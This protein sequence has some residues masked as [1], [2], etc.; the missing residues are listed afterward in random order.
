M[1]QESERENQNSLPVEHRCSATFAD[2]NLIQVAWMKAI[3]PTSM[4]LGLLNYF[5]SNK[6]PTH[7]SY[8]R[9]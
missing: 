8:W 9:N 4:P 7:S 6:A 1:I 5:L 3:I 2:V